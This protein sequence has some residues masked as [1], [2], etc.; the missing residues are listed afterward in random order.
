MKTKEYKKIKGLK[1]EN[2]RDNMTTPEL[3]LNML[4][5]VSTKD[6]VEVEEPIGLEDNRKVTKRGGGVAKVARDAL[7]LE[8]KSVI[9]KENAISFSKVLEEVT[10][11]ISKDK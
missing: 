10:K 7:E 4:A 8:K 1:K 2:L 11:N 3:I 5:E 9:T 6:I